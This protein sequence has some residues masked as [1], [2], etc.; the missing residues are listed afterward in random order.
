MSQFQITESLI[1]ITQNLEKNKKMGIINNK[2]RL[3][4]ANHVQ[5]LVLGTK[6]EKL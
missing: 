2:S 1:N 4:G 3:I 5:I 6:V